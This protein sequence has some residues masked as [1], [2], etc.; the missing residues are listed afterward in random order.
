MIFL[1][2]WTQLSTEKLKFLKNHD[3]SK[4]IPDEILWRINQFFTWCPD[5][6]SNAI[7]LSF[8]TLNL[9]FQMRNWIIFSRKHPQPEVSPGIIIS[10]TIER[11]GDSRGLL[12]TKTKFLSVP[13]Y[14]FHA[15]SHT[16]RCQR[17]RG[18]SLEVIQKTERTFCGP[19]V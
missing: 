10:K 3:I 4:T 19:H 17:L 2:L 5:Y 7:F 6:V 14:F 16:V 18:K 12:N 11:W 15:L 9:V 13:D 8:S 1:H